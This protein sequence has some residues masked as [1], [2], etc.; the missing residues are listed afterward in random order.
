MAAFF[1]DHPRIGVP[2]VV[3]ER[4]SARVLCTRFMPGLK[5]SHV[6]DRLADQRAAGDPG[7]Q[8]QLSAVLAALLEAY[9]RQTLEAGVFQADPHPGNLL[10]RLEDGAL[11]LTVLDFGCAKQ[12]DPSERRAL[13]ALLGAVLM[14]DVASLAA[15][16]ETFGFQTQSGTR[17]GLEALARGALSELSLVKSDGGGFHGQLDLVAR[18]AAF[19][20]QLEAD[21]ITKLPESFV[22]LGRVF[23]TL[24][25]LFVHYRPDVDATASVLPVVLAALAGSAAQRAA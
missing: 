3:R 21:P 17:A 6:L 23:G 18:F 8:A 24:S 25:G 5:I 9:A 16:L 19:G 13:L 12:L 20:R 10:V 15:A 14:R 11:D 1:A 2:E 4:S 7:A 22:M